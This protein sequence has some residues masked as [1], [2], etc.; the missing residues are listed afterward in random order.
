MKKSNLSRR[1]L[2]VFGLLAVF[3]GQASWATAGTLGGMS[4]IITD[5]KTGAPLAGVHLQI[6]SPSQTVATTT[7][8]HGHYVAL[9]LQ[10]DDYTLTAE[11]D[12]YATRSVSGYSIY[13]DQ[14]QL[15]DL[16]LDAGSPGGAGDAETSSPLLRD[17][18][19]PTSKP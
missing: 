19:P 6:S 4:G 17:D 9:S 8:A 12:G 11:K 16:R 10:P 18:T 13:A 3:I 2:S 14:T 15:Y 7:D 5:A 1:W